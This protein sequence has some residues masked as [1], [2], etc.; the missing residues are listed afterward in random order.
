MRKL[1]AELTYAFV[2]GLTVGRAE[3]PY[4]CSSDMWEAFEI[5]RHVRGQ[6]DGTIEFLG[7][8]RSTWRVRYER[9][10]RVAA[11]KVEY[12]GKGRF[13]IHGGF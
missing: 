13:T 2:K 8:S 4:F 7:K 5:G 3:N 6:T 12:L 10:N 9:Q 1:N 11:Y